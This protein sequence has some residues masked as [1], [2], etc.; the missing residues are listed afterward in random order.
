MNAVALVLAVSLATSPVGTS[1]GARA[2]PQTVDALKLE[3]A[4]TIVGYQA[5]LE[6]QENR[7]AGEVRELKIRLDEAR[8]IAAIRTPTV[9]AALLPPADVPMPTE[10]YDNADDFWLGIV[11]GGGVVGALFAAAAIALAAGGAFK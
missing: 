9:A 8:E 5:R 10:G 11:V 6:I 4:K 7:H 2:V 1:T 3:L